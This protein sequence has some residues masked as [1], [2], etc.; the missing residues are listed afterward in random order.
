M[1]LELLTFPAGL[2]L[3]VVLVVEGCGIFV[4]LHNVIILVRMRTHP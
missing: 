1:S 2:L 3:Q 4:T